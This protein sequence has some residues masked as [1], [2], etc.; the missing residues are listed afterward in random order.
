LGG[1]LG[2]SDHS[3]S[4]L[5][6]DAMIVSRISRALV[7][8]IGLLAF[9]AA[10]EVIRPTDDVPRPVKKPAEL[11]LRHDTFTFVRIRYSTQAGRRGMSWATDYPDS[12]INLTARVAADTGLKTDPKGKVLQL[13]DPE[14]KKYP[15]LYLIEPESLEFSEDEVRS[16][17]KYLLE[18]GFLMVDDFWG[19]REWIAFEEELRLLFPDREIIDLPNDHPIFNGVFPLTEKPQVPGIDW[20]R[21]GMTYE[22]NHGPG[23]QEVHYRA[24][25]DDRKRIM[26]LICHNTDLGDGWEREGENEEY[27]HR[28]SEKVAYPMGI[29][30]IF[31]AMTH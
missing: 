9:C 18:G 27:F 22:P 23:S 1:F 4:V 25:V 19:D 13:T 10:Q 7:A 3:L 16:L 6:V 5:K 26:I 28:F 8:S 17:R 2:D 31:Y 20:G 11:K 21:R 15:F 14:L 12:D 29:N 24:I 30:I